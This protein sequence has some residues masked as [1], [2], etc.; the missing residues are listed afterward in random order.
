MSHDI[1]NTLLRQAHECLEPTVCLRAHSG[2]RHI[3][4]G[5]P[6]VGTRV[7]ILAQDLNVTV[8]N[9]TTGEEIR[10][11]VIDLERNYQ[12]LAKANGR[13]RKEVRPLQMS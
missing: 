6:P 7:L 11:L 12:P 8:I 5:R 1:D 13:T 9:A 3:S 4:L 2:M 10:E